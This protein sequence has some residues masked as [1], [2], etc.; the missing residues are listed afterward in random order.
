ML[1]KLERPELSLESRAALVEMTQTQGW[2]I[3]SEILLPWKQQEVLGNATFS[4]MPSRQRH[5]FI[6]Q[7]RVLED[8]VPLVEEFS[9]EP[10]EEV[11][12]SEHEED[13]LPDGA[14]I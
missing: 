10:E 14:A 4:G 13:W 7:A 2:R 12:E 5:N 8:V 11:E 1:S 9:K 6:A 3:F